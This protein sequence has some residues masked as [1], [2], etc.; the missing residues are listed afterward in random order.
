MQ[1]SDETIVVC[2]AGRDIWALIAVTDPVRSEAPAT[3]AQIHR[4]DLRS[5][6]LTGDNA[7]TAHNVGARVQIADVRAELL[8]DGKAQV[9]REFIAH[10]G[11]TA[12]AGDGINDSQALLAASVGVAM[13]GNATDVAAESADV[14]LMHDDLR[15]LPFLVEHARRARRVIIQNV[16]V[17]LGA[18]AVFLA[19]MA[20]GAATLWMA[21][22]ADM[23]ASLLVTFNG[24]RM[25]RRLP[26]WGS[27]GIAG[28]GAGGGVIERSTIHVPAVADLQDHDDERGPVHAVEDAIRSGADSKTRRRSR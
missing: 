7:A 22:A 1:R 26:G 17:A 14:V 8:P 6:L 12:M 20:A 13:G 25:L 15:M 2:G 10:H 19:F 18:K 3:V 4:Q 23:G 24:L 16:S 9:I 27:G 5:V 21:V 28:T 11:P